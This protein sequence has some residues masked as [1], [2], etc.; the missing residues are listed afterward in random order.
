MSY[1]R[2]LVWLFILSQA[3]LAQVK[4]TSKAETDRFLLCARSRFQKPVYM[5]VVG[6]WF[7]A[8]MKCSS[9]LEEVL[10]ELQERNIAV[11]END[12]AV[13]LV[14]ERI[15]PDSA[16]PFAQIKPSGTRS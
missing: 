12:A 4:H 15:R 1:A 6:P 2:C 14:P 13:L 10:H 16:S 9:D 3:T 7:D 8:A 11:F 5:T